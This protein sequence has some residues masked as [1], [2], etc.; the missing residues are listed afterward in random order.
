MFAYLSSHGVCVYQHHPTNS[1][2]AATKQ[3]VLYSSNRIVKMNYRFLEMTVF[4][5]TIYDYREFYLSPDGSIRL[6]LHS[7]HKLSV[8]YT[9]RYVFF[10][11][12]YNVLH[13]ILCSCS[14]AFLFSIHQFAIHMFIT[15]CALPRYTSSMVPGPFGVY[16]DFIKRSHLNAHANVVIVAMNGALGRPPPLLMDLS[17]V[18]E[19]SVVVDINSSRWA[20]AKSY[21]M[22]AAS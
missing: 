10:S 22:R 20:L 18:H 5:F 11:S 9:T 1:R 21:W 14:A 6:G 8:L 16:G 3:Q 13:S 19:L 2:Y 17:P 12:R 15:I 4:P 7:F